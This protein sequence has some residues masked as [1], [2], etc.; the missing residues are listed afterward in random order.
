MV[1]F[2]RRGVAAKQQL[3][4]IC[5]NMMDNCLSPNSETGGVGCDNMTM[6]VIALLKGKTIEEWYNDIAN[7]VANGDGPC[8]PPEYGKH[9]LPWICELLLIL[10]TTAEMRGPG[11]HN[12]FEDSGE[13]YDMDLDPVARGGRPARIILLGN[14]T[15][16]LTDSDEQEVFDHDED[17]KD[18]ENQVGKSPVAANSRNQREGTPGPR[19]QDPSNQQQTPDSGE[20]GNPFDTP[21]S[22]TSDKSDSIEMPSTATKAIPETAI[23]EKLTN[24]PKTKSK[25]Q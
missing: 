13:D 10:G 14:G 15:E 25:E 21:S 11:V 18:L 9:I 16:V 24:P 5:E 8:A 20:T 12:R 2:V 7:R 22:T 17:D 4:K 23:P 1:E 19:S 3:S 6:V